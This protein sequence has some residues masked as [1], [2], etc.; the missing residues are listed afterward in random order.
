MILFLLTIVQL[1]NWNSIII[2]NVE[3]LKVR[4]AFFE[5]CCAAAF[6]SKESDRVS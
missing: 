1:G 6:R 3:K 5:V 2:K 4:G